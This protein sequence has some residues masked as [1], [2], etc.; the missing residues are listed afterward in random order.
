MRSSAAGRRYARAL[1]SLAQDAGQVTELRG[2][3]DGMRK[4]LADAPD[5]GG[6]PV[7]T[8]VP[9]CRRVPARRQLTGSCG[10]YRRQ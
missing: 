6:V 5:V 7:F 4:L 10:T 1:F 2:E 9:A 8:G 3:L